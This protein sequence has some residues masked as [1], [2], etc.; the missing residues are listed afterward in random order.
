M[1]IKLQVC[2]QFSIV[3]HDKNYRKCT[4]NLQC[5]KR[6]IQSVLHL[7]C[8]TQV[9]KYTDAQGTEAVSE[10]HHP[11]CSTGVFCQ[12][13]ILLA[14]GVWAQAKWIEEIVR[15]IGW[16]FWFAKSYKGGKD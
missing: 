8:F 14:G 2:S 7:T 13:S 10:Y 16:S 3:G 6:H 4:D 12:Q 5:V 11:G 9:V 1:Q 15:K